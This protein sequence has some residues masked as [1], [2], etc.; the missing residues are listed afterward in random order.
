[1]SETSQS[2]SSAQ[3]LLY[4]KESYTY[5]TS[6]DIILMNDTLNGTY[7]I[8][9]TAIMGCLGLRVILTSVNFTRLCSQFFLWDIYVLFLLILV[10]A[11]RYIFC[12]CCMIVLFLGNHTQ[13]C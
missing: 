13:H 11:I 1:M 6:K 4:Y 12:N 7:F 5:T 8:L 9:R 2:D 10:T 3:T